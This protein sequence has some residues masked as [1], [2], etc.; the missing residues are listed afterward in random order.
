M[1]NS[2]EIIRWNSHKSYLT[3]VADAGFPTIPTEWVRKGETG[4]LAEILDRRG[5]QDAVVKPAISASAHGTIK[6]DKDSLDEGQA[7]LDGLTHSGDALIQPYLHDFTTTGETSVIWLGGEQ[8][9]SVRRPSGMHTSL[10]VA[11]LG[12]PLEP[13]AEEL[14][15]AGAVYDWI[16]P[17]PLYARIDV[18]NTVDY[19]L[20]VLELELVEPALYLRHSQAIAD[21]F[22]L[23]VKRLLDAAR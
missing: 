5:W 18:L 17:A 20:L 4:D 10:E 6:V 2:P 22:A 3:R 8:S 14:A 11:H 23:S 9:H 1:Q 12:A 16:T 21:R 13:S 7:H 15:L 19:G